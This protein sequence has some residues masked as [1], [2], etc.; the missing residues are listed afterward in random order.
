MSSLFRQLSY[1]IEYVL[2]AVFA[3]A[4]VLTGDEHWWRWAVIAGVW[5]AADSHY[6]PSNQE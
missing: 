2:S 1:V 6:A 3:V 4:W 5:A